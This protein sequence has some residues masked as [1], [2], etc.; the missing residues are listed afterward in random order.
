MIWLKRVL[1]AL[2]GLLLLAVAGVALF[3][4]TFDPNA[5]RAQ[6]ISAVE[7]RLGRSFRLEGN[8]E[9]SLYPWLGVTADGIEI[10]NAEGFGPE[11]LLRA[12][13][14][15][16]RARLLPLIR[17]RLEMDTVR[18]EGAIINLAVNEAGVANWQGL[19]GP[20]PA[21]AGVDGPAPSAPT[22]VAAP[23]A[24]STPA[25]TL[26][27]AVLAIGGVDITDLRL[28][29]EDRQQQRRYLLSDFDAR[30]G[31]LA[32]GEPVPL[33][34]MGRFEASQPELA[35]AFTLGGTLQH[36][37]SA[38][39]FKMQPLTLGVDLTGPQLPQGKARIDAVG[40]LLATDGGRQLELTGLQVNGLAHTLKADLKAL[41]RE[42]SAPA[43]AGMLEAAGPDLAVLFRAFAD[44][45]LAADLA[46]LPERAFEARVL[47]DIDPRAGRFDVP[48]LTL[49]ALGTRIEGKAAQTGETV[50][51]EL[52]GQGPDLPAL[53]RALG[54]AGLGA[55]LPLSALGDVLTQQD[56]PRPFSLDARLSAGR[57]GATLQLP[58]LEAELLGA[59][60]VADG[61]SLAGLDRGAPVVQGEVSAEGTHLSA[62]L[63]A[64]G[65]LSGEAG[66]PLARAAASLAAGGASPFSLKAGL[67]LD[68]GRGRLGLEGLDL[69]LPGISAGGSLKANGDAV[70]GTLKIS[71]EQPRRLL[72][73][74]GQA[75]LGERLE[76]F[77]LSLPVQGQGTRLRITPLDLKAAFVAGQGGQGPMELRLRSVASADTAAGDY[78]FDD[79]ALT[80]LGMNVTG[81]LKATGV[82]QGTLGVKALEGRLDAPVFDLRQVV[83]ALGQTLPPMADARALTAVGLTLQVHSAAESAKVSDVVLLLDGARIAGDID[84]RSLQGPNARFRLQADSLDL[85]RYLPPGEGA[86]ATPE[87][88]AAGAATEVPVALLRGLV[89]DGEV[90]IDKLRMA[91]LALGEVV[92]TVKAADG[93]ITA[94][95][96]SAQLYEGSYQ[97]S[98]AIDATG[99]V[100]ALRIDSSLT[101]IQAEPLLEDLQGRSRL[102]GRGDVT[103][104]LAAQGA[105]TEAL[106]RSL[107]GE[108]RIDFRDG[109]IK[110]VNIGKLLRGLESGS[111]AGAREEA[112][113]FAELGATIRC[114]QGVCA[115]DDLSLKG[116]LLRVSGQGTV[117]NLG[118]DTIDYHLQ[119]VLVGTALGQ[120][121]KEL[122]LLDGV[123]IPIRVKGRTTDPRFIIDFGRLLEQKAKEELRRQIER[124]LG[125]D[126]PGGAVPAV[127]AA[128]AAAE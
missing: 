23:T 127:G 80:G 60:L 125:S 74:F 40:N 1:L 71:G 4:V 47:A 78:A 122:A 10:G 91:G 46:R 38:G 112:T 83:G 82:G 92:L 97:G 56:A 107:T 81:A 58:R 25:P 13:R 79:F 37:L 26:P 61:L 42:D 123:P 27:F 106:R 2:F 96:L 5:Y 70:E 118:D 20:A 76:H 15:A 51:A 12:G 36:D 128:A 95:P 63:A 103:L 7:Q 110:G 121:G 126:L 17:S 31:L 104:K 67:D 45:V 34:A 18:L 3:L 109:A 28:Q 43:V 108:I 100:A 68:P 66:A 22:R 75:E 98:V 114:T 9:L 90:R 54:A 21:V 101:G 14:V 19:T 120:G 30:T 87:A 124:R 29:F 113:D 89:L 35:G 102:R 64:A 84:L 44:P 50:A 32:A 94:E 115:N 24:A 59:R 49:K 16:M 11:P 116:P 48:Q 111:F 8:V 41:L 117:V 6:I 88:V 52:R 57:A 72:A 62:L 65:A 73:A 86:A 77:E 119:A 39:R 69:R 55:G 33:E 105:M 85:D 99:E 53:L 93:Q